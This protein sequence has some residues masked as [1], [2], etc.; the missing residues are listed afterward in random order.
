[1]IVETNEELKSQVK[2]F[3]NANT[4]GVYRT[5]EER[6]SLEY[7][8]EIEED[9]YS[10]QPEIFSFAE[11]TRY[12]KKKVLEIGVGAGTDFLQWVRAGAE[13]Y[14]LDLT[15]EAIE[16]VRNRLNL[17]GLEAKEYKVGDAENLPYADNSFDLVYSW[18]VIHHSP[19]TY[20]ALSEIYRVLKPGGK[21][22]LMIY[23]RRSLLAYFFWIKHALLKLRPW[24]SL[25][26]VLW[27]KMESIGTK[28]FTVSEIEQELTKYKVEKVRV[29][30]VFTY[31]DKLARFNK[32]MQFASA[33]VA[34]ILGRENI[35]WFLTIEFDKK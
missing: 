11:F 23:N 18:G 10:V 4:C 15:P 26:W 16:H 34:N 33:T 35:G 22:K 6:Y 7:F 32:L 5:D 2:E 28:G 1:M 24:K 29:K 25:A 21:A 3:W 8:E 27:H 13:A 31:Y 14:G 17:Y 12:N 30:T 19:N 9:R 20:K